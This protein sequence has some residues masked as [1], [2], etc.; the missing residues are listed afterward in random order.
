MKRR[1]KSTLV[2]V[3]ARGIL[4]ADF[5]DGVCQWKSAARQPGTSVVEGFTTALSLGDSISREVWLLSDEWFSQRLQLNPAQVA[6]LSEAQMTRALAFEAEPFSGIPMASAALAF[7]N[8]G[9]GAFDVVALPV[10]TRDRLLGAASFRSCGLEGIAHADAPPEDERALRKWLGDW[11][12]R[13]GTEQVPVLGAPAP[14]PSPKRFQVAGLCMAA[15]ALLLLVAGKWWLSSGIRDLKISNDEFSR[16]TSELAA[17]NQNIQNATKEID[18]L[19]SE[20]ESV[21]SVASRRLSVPALLNGIAVQRKDEIV[22]RKIETEGASASTLHGVSLTSD[23]VDE[24]G[25][26]LK[27]SLRGSGWSVFPRKKTGLKKLPNGGPWEFS[28]GIIH[29][30]AA[31]EGVHLN[32]SGDN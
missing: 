10:E 23:A 16:A 9:E 28:L 15:A 18:T 29:Q 31:R 27:E 11:M 30:E 7:R 32:T 4:H 13:I 21:N 19:R 20:I 24:L 14:P 3:S 8:A 2:V 22:L 17:V 5:R 26:V 1:Q 6:G 12:E 25:I